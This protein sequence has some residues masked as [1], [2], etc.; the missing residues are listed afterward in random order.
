[1]SD[2]EAV[3]GSDSCPDVIDCVT[4]VTAESE[5]GLWCDVNVVRAGVGSD[6]CPDVDAWVGDVTEEEETGL[7]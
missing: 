1:M 6:S 7:F 5:T 3:V 2:L 4:D